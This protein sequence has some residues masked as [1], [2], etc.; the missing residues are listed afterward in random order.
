MLYI[1]HVSWGW[2][3]QRPHFLAEGLTQKFDITVVTNERVRKKNKLNKRK[4]NK[5]NFKIIYIVPLSRFV[6]IKRFSDY[7][8]R[9]IIKRIIKKNDIIW[10]T[11]PN[12]IL[13]IRD[14]CFYNKN[15]IYDA[16][17]DI[18]AFPSV[19]NNR[20]Y[21]SKLFYFEKK[22]YQRANVI[23]ASSENLKNELISRYGQKKVNVVNN[24][25]IPN[26]WGDNFIELPEKIKNYFSSS[27]A[28]KLTYIGTISTWMDFKSLLLILNTFDE[29]EIVLFGPC[30][31]IP[32]KHNRLIVFGPV[33]HKYI[34]KIM[35]YSNAMIM[36]F[37][38]NRLIKSVNPVKLYE[39][40]YSLKPCISVQYNETSKF[41]DYVYLYSG[42]IELLK[43]IK[44]LIL[45]KLNAKRGSKEI[46]EFCSVNT[47]G[48]RVEFIMNI[49]EKECKLVVPQ[50]NNKY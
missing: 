27:H 46:K 12:L 2:I 5:L 14:N 20:E 1:M 49:I 15:I 29:I 37:I 25:I 21:R 39:Y 32:P 36:P 41:E 50:A 48:K 28:V 23:F 30:D 40:I 45:E 33:E 22:L 31:V 8:Y 3:K 24:A 4:T 6:F 7:I 44:L 26:T 19:E 42:Q 10:Y 11:Y 16:M 9:R 47:W 38:L 17:D 18:L 13:D 34:F 43:L 35:E